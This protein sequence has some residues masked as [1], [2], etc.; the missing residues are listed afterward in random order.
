MPSKMRAVFLVQVFLN[1]IASYIS[2]V[3][4]YD[5]IFFP[6]LLLLILYLVLK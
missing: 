6:H 4:F 2:V 1:R 5:I 3:A